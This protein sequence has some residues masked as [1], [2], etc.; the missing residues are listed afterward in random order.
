MGGGLPIQKPYFLAVRQ[1][2]ER[3]AELLGVV[4]ALILC[5]NGIDARTLCLQ[6]R[7]GPSLAVAEH[8][9]GLRAVRQRVFEQHARTVGQVPARV[10][11]QGVNLDPREGFGCA[12]HAAVQGSTTSTPTSPKSRTFRVAT[13]MPRERAIAAIWQSAGA[14]GRPAE[15]R[16]AAIS[17]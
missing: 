16:P 17:A 5:R 2:D 14:M 3:Y 6:H 9:V 1:E 12:A 11:Q 13:A 15:R 10:L 7:H 8:I 4:A